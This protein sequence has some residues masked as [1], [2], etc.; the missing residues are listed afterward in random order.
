MPGSCLDFSTLPPEASN[1]YRFSITEGLSRFYIDLMND[2]DARKVLDLDFLGL[3]KLHHL[4]LIQVR[5][6]KN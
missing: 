6:L 1:L 2:P 3:K 4:F 5:H